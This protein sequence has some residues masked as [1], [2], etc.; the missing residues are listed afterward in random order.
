MN[1]SGASQPKDGA[2]DS[3]EDWGLTLDPEEEY[4]FDE[5]L[6]VADVDAEM[7]QVL[8]PTFGQSVI[9]SAENHNARQIRQDQHQQGVVFYDDYLANHAVASGST[10]MQQPSA[11]APSDT[12]ST[13]QG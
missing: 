12:F 2:S 5:T 6:P 3:E 9:A 10:S 8:D 4:R 7:E 13:I 11:T 1:R